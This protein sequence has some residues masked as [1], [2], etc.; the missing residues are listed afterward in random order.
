LSF[1]FFL[2]IAQPLNDLGNRIY[3]IYP[4]IGSGNERLITILLCQFVAALVAGTVFA[5]AGPLPRAS[6]LLIFPTPIGIICVEMAKTTYQSAQNFHGYLRLECT[7]GCISVLPYDPFC[8]LFGPYHIRFGRKREFVGEDR[9]N[10][11]HAARYAAAASTIAV[12]S[13][14]QSER[15]ASSS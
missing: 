12:S 6:S 13:A 8:F 14:R 15:R 9:E 3:I 10:S 1:S 5:I 4:Q 2:L 11:H 7:R